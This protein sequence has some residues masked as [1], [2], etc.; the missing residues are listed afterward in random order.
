MLHLFLITLAFTTIFFI[1]AAL[2]FNFSKRRTA[3]SRHPLS[4]TCQQNGGTMCC[5]C[6]STLQTTIQKQ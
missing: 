4:A 6:T 5:S 2:I 3:R 1:G